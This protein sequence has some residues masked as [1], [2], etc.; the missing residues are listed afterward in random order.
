MEQSVQ[1]E[2]C[3]ETNVTSSNSINRNHDEL[4]INLKTNNMK[5]PT[6]FPIPSDSCAAAA[7]RNLLLN[8]NQTMTG[9]PAIVALD[10]QLKDAKYK[11][12]SDM[13]A[14][15]E[16]WKNFADVIGAS[17]LIGS[18]STEQSSPTPGFLL[19]GKSS[20]INSDV[21]DDVRSGEEM[22]ATAANS[23]NG[24]PTTGDV[25]TVCH[26][27]IRDPY[28]MAIGGG[29]S[30]ATNGHAS[31]SDLQCNGSLCNH[32]GSTFSSTDE[33]VKK[34]CMATTT[35]AA[36]NDPLFSGC[37]GS[38]KKNRY[39]SGNFS[40]S[41]DTMEAIVQC[42]VFLKAFSVRLSLYSSSLLLVN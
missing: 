30:G 5:I 32:N 2:A 33:E 8:S 7:V 4:S 35:A 10:D 38:W 25:C 21:S 11:C 31:S 20:Q 41:G 37:L 9:S 23:S 24:F 12:L 6:A 40:V 27:K 3:G 16:Q 13:K 28:Q 1:G 18:D 29:C 26:G 17:T 39:L 19:D 36:A 22:G 42:L 34:G 15:S 14:S